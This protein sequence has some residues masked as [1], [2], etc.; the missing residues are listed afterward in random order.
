MLPGLLFVES[1]GL[2]RVDT[3]LSAHDCSLFP[4]ELRAGFDLESFVIRITKDV[5]GELDLPALPVN[6]ALQ[7]GCSMRHAVFH[8]L[9]PSCALLLF[10]AGRDLSLDPFAGAIPQGADPGRF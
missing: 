5:D 8:R 1:P 10:S 2:R 6:R 3:R 4:Q 7:I 9:S